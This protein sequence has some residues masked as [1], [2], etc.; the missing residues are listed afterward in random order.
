MISYLL[1]RFYPVMPVRVVFTHF[2]YSDQNTTQAENQMNQSELELNTRSR[3]Q[4]RENACDQVQ[5]GF[6]FTFDWLR[7]W[8][9][10]FMTKRSNAKPKQLTKYFRQSIEN[11]SMLFKPCNS[12]Y[13]QQERR[14][15]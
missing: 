6:S 13:E 15:K 9:E 14:L 1:S 5:F 10:I 8:R 4:A 3:R 2:F 12:G 7:K 11:R